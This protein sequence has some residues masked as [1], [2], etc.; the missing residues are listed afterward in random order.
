METSSLSMSCR[1]S[2]STGVA[3]G[4][5]CRAFLY[6][7]VKWTVLAVCLLVCFLCVAV[8]LLVPEDVCGTF[9]KSSRRADFVDSRRWSRSFS[10]RPKSERPKPWRENKLLQVQ[11]RDHHH[12]ESSSEEYIWGMRGRHSAGRSSSDGRATAAATG[13]APIRIKL[14]HRNSPES[15]FRKE[16]S[17][18]GKAWED[19]REMDVVRLAGFRKRILAQADDNNWR[20]VAATAAASSGSNAAAPGAAGVSEAPASMATIQNPNAGGSTV[21]AAMNSFQTSL[22]SGSTLGS[23]QYFVSFSIGTPAQSFFLVADT[24]SD[25]IWVQC[26]PCT[27]CYPQKDPLYSPSNSS[28]FVPVPCFSSECNLVPA[29]PGF[30]CDAETYPGACAYVYQYADSSTTKGVF[31]FETATLQKSSSSSSSSPSSSSSIVHIQNVAFGCGTDNQVS[32]QGADGVLGL[33]QG[34]LSFTSQI[35]YAYGDVFS[36]CLVS[37]LEPVS[38]SSSLLFGGDGG[39]GSGGLFANHSSSQLQYTPILS[40]PRSGTLYY[41]GIQEV[42]VAGSVLDIPSSAWSFDLLG[43]GGTTIDSGTTLTYFVPAA[44]S[45]ILTAFKQ[46]LLQEFPEVTLETTTAQT[47]DLCVNV[48]AAAA[49]SSS[50]QPYPEFR[51]RF[52]NEADFSPPP[53]NYLVE[54]AP[55]VKCLA[56]QGLQSDSF[57]FNTIGNLLQQNFLV[58]YDRQSS[59]IGFARSHCAA[60]AD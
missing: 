47:F 6:S 12:A 3:G 40:N 60:A 55:D 18:R 36:Y 11:V 8:L 33:G 16:Y 31:A 42:R 49:D 57:G 7:R 27:Q 53:E 17:T 2:R 50:V 13:G 26:A 20:N 15:P 59:R 30:P 44:Y 48:S 46:V 28:S 52:Q 39:G 56:L 45:V 35:G 51:I 32:F 4:V 29:T 43:D 10:W 25:L 22:V 38:V 54:I 24:G 19:A 21:P 14:V 1:S 23:G 34:P 58:V 37:Y 41:V 5:S 9:V